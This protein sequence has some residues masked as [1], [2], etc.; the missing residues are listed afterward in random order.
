MAQLDAFTF[1]NTIRDRL[2]D[3]SLD[4]NFVRIPKLTEIC[5]KLWSGLADTG[6]LVSDLWVEGAYPAESSE[7]TLNSL[8]Q[9]GKFATQL[10]ACLDHEKAVPRHRPL[11]THQHQ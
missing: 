4:R 1:A 9:R 5:R 3:F 6:G 2:V 10:V 8:A 11:Y 7:E